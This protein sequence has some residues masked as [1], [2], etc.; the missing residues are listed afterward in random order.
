MLV[1]CTSAP[2]II[3]VKEAARAA[4]TPEIGVKRAAELHAHRPRAD[5]GHTIT[6]AA[7]PEAPP[8]NTPGVQNLLPQVSTSLGDS[9]KSVDLEH[10]APADAARSAKPEQPDASERAP[11]EAADAIP[12]TNVSRHRDASPALGSDPVKARMVEQDDVLNGQILLNEKVVADQCSAW[13]G[14]CSRT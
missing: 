13:R 3:E 6:P 1:P 11:G 10:Q 9:S 5:G 4:S 14:A 2:A 12:T 7:A 8:R